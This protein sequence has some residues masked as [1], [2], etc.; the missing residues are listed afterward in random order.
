M[1]QLEEVV[2]IYRVGKVQERALRGVD[3]AVDDGELVAIIGPCGAG[4]ST[5]MN[6]LGCLDMPTS[7]RYILDG[8]DVRSL[9][10]DQLAWVRSRKIANRPSCWSRLA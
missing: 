6:I 3:L 2:K 7:G 8:T 9:S 4:T 10:N 1:L 5:L